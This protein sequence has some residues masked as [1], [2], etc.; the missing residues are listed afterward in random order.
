MI[1]WFIRVQKYIFNC[2]STICF[3]KCSATPGGNLVYHLL[4]CPANLTHLP[5]ASRQG[6]FSHCQRHFGRSGT[7]LES[8]THFSFVRVIL[9]R[10]YPGGFFQV[11]NTLFVARS[12][13]KQ[14]PKRR[15]VSAA[16]CGLASNISLIS[17]AVIPSVASQV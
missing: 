2:M 5:P 8:R 10:R 13:C 4:G 9:A 1:L 16:V 11:I 12:L 6:P 17:S 7:T 3:P 14:C 15:I